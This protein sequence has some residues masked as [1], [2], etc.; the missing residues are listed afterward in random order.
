MPSYLDNLILRSLKADW[1]DTMNLSLGEPHLCDQLQKLLTV[2]GRSNYPQGTTPLITTFIH[3][4]Y[5][6][7]TARNWK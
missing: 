3:V 7:F 5:M 2:S 4:G 1:A 6:G